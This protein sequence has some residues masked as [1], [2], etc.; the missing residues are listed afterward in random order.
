MSN[1]SANLLRI[2]DMLLTSAER[3][4]LRRAVLSKPASPTVKRGELRVVSLSRGAS[5][6]IETFTSD[7]KAFHNNILLPTTPEVLCES[8]S[9][10]GQ[11]N[12][13]AEG[14]E[15]EYR[16][17]KNGNDIIFGEK[18]FLNVMRNFTP[19]ATPAE[20]NDR[21]KKHILSGDEPFLKLL[22]VS[23]G[24]GR[25]YDKKQAKFRQINKFLEHIA[26]VEGY[27]P[28]DKIRICDLCCGKSYLSF[29]AYHYF[30]NIKKMTV[31]MTGVDLKADV[32]EYCSKTA[33]QLHFDGLEFVCGDITQYLTE[34][35]PQLVISLHACDT[36]TDIVLQKAAE[37]RADV[38]L[39]TPCCHHQ[40]NH[41]LNCPEL[42]FIADYSMLRQKLCDAATDAMR[43]KLLEAKGYSTAA[44]EL[45]DPE[46]TPKNIM[47][48]AI[49]KKKF[50]PDGAEAERLMRE[51][52]EIENFL[53]RK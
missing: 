5:I 37:W 14:A 11:I 2:A 38:I 44:I 9:G 25:I 35:P 24:S 36:A 13:F 7:N 8:I 43:L 27:L 32:I 33:A 6:Q 50:D 53:I 46:E 48:R 1:F 26:E 23:D 41:T 18:K 19:Q 34:T 52:R 40:L 29:A 10:Y 22:G 21:T 42:S 30:A 45:I 20:K 47:L 28:K 12:I 15:C 16:C 51:Y 3:G 49:R 17:S 31:H 4:L 39:S